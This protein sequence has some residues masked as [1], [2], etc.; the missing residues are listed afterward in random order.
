MMQTANEFRLPGNLEGTILEKIIRC[1]VREIMAARTSFP[2]ASIESALERAEPVR[3]LK[4]ALVSGRPP[5]V[6]SE[7]KKRPLPPVS[8]AAISIRSE[9]PGNTG[10]PAP[11][12]CR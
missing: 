1:K 9:L 8:Y 3:S 6:I 2:A 4:K 11:R 10:S 5:A 7:I 12:L